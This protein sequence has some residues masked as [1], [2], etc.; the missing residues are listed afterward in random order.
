[1]IS[2]GGSD[3]DLDTR[4]SSYG[5]NAWLLSMG[6][7]VS[8]TVHG[9]QYFFREADI[10]RPSLT[11][12]LGDCVDQSSSP[13]ADDRPP[14]NLQTPWG[15]AAV[16]YSG[17]KYFVISRHGFPPNPVPTNWPSNQPLP[18][19][20]NVSFFDGHGELV[21]LDYLWQLYWH[22]DYQPPAKRPGLP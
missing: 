20:V 15:D 18:G 8:A 3:P 5:M 2:G 10:G 6:V 16:P 13:R 11:P 1:M 4:V 21:K 14:R 19:A 12:L 9:S 17:M 22:K 7:V